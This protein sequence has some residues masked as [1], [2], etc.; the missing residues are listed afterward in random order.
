MAWHS[1]AELP[2]LALQRAVIPHSA[3]LVHSCPTA[4]NALHTAPL[5]Q[6]SPQASVT[7]PSTHASPI[8]G[9]GTHVPAA[10]QFERKHD[11][12]YVAHWAPSERNGTHD[13]APDGEEE[14]QVR[15]VAHSRV[16]VQ[17]PEDFKGAHTPPAQYRPAWHF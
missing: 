12:G 5:H 1:R 9:R 10:L 16:S 8:W 4:V 13:P 14:A 2:A 15:S 11:S 6:P 3:S 17:V 7:S